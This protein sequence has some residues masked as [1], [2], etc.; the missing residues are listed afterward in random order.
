MTNSDLRSRASTIITLMDQADE[1]KTEIADRFADAKNSGL[2]VSAL[3]KAIKL[4]RLDATAREKH[5]TEQT[6]LLMYLEE[7]EGRR[8]A[9]E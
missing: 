3:R 1:I 8:E 4:H 6:D 7:I 2:T 9:A 5:E